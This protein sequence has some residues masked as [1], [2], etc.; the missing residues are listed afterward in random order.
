MRVFI[1]NIEQ[2]VDY[3]E[4]SQNFLARLPI[5]HC[6]LDIVYH[7]HV[8]QRDLRSLGRDAAETNAFR[9]V[10]DFRPDV[11]VYFQAW[12]D[13][14]LSPAVFSR[15]RQMG[16]PIIAYIW[17]SNLYPRWNEILLFE[18]ADCLV[19]VDSLDAYLRWRMMAKLYDRRK[20]IAFGVG[21]YFL[22]Q[23]ARDYKK[24]YDVTLI[25][26]IEGQRA[27]LLSYL[28]AKLGEHGVRFRHAGG[29]VNTDGTE[30]VSKAWLSWDDYDAIVRQSRLCI[31]S[32]TAATRLH[33]KGK[34]FEAMARGTPCLIDSNTEARRF[35]P[36][37]VVGFYE[38]DED[39]I[40]QIVHYLS[41]KSE[42]K[43]LARNASDWMQRCFDFRE[44]YSRLLTYVVAGTGSVPVLEHVEQQWDHIWS[45]GYAMSPM[46]A[47]IVTSMIK[48]LD[49]KGDFA[50]APPWSAPDT[51]WM[52]WR[53]KIPGMDRRK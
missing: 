2:Y 45:E 39:C 18:N 1:F 53:S 15:I 8:H 12:K 13:D 49:T 7:D 51:V 44:F 38:N 40:R 17:D 11:V 5:I 33:L 36:P 27:D 41:H 50:N 22:P 29:M 43:A 16:I 47:D 4:E 10:E 42:L 14:D 3:Q 9:A 24:I 32:Q 48:F 19:I 34:I 23:P 25:G 46:L 37:N 31:S 26:S 52:R 30:P 35:F 6:G 21:L 28:E 20:I